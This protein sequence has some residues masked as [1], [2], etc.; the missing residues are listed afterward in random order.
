[1]DVLIKTKIFPNSKKAEIRK[2]DKDSFE[3]KV[4]AGPILGAVN[5]EVVEML[6]IYFKISKSKIQMIRGGRARNKLFKI[7]SH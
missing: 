4:K 1:M 7:I 2:V 5:R 3:I 6:A